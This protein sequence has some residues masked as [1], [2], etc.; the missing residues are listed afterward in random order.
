MNQVVFDEQ[1]NAAESDLNQEEKE[2]P[3]LAS[4]GDINLWL[5]EDKNGNVFVRID[6]PFLESEPVFFNDDVKPGL[7]QL[8][9]KWRQQ[10]N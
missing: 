1:D 8:V 5:D 3:P 10:R 4:N 2:M 6:A 9:E 7:N